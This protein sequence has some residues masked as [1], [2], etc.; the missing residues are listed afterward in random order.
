MTAILKALFFLHLK[1]DVQSRGEA[2]RALQN[3]EFFFSPFLGMIC[4]GLDFDSGPDKD[5]LTV[6]IRTTASFFLLQYHNIIQ[7][8]PD[9]E[10]LNNS[11]PEIE[12]QKCLILQ[13]YL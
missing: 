2:S 1:K 6:R 5:T 7:K 4:L 9:L 11:A 12:A 3:M 13:K 8:D 10:F